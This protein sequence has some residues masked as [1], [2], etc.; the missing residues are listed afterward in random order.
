MS[1]GAQTLLTSSLKVLMLE[2]LLEF[3]ILALLVLPREAFP[4]VPL[5]LRLSL[6]LAMSRKDQPSP[7]CNQPKPEVAVAR[8]EDDQGK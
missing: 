1:K 4:K 3:P 6:E 7:R 2:I 8:A 5:L